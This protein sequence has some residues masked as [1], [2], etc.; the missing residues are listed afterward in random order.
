MQQRV[1]LGPLR[2]GERIVGVMATI[3]DVTA[4]HRRRASC[5]R[6][7]R[8][9]ACARDRAAKRLRARLSGAG[10][11][12]W[13]CARSRS[14]AWRAHRAA[15]RR[16]TR[17]ARHRDF[18]VLSSALQLLG[19]TDIDVT[20][21]ARRAAAA[22]PDADLRIQ[23]ALALGEQQHAGARST[24][25]VGALDDP[26][27]NVRFHAIEALGRLRAADAVDALADI[28]ES[29]DFFLAFPAI[30]ALARISDSRV[31]PRLVPLLR[32]RDVASRVAEAL[33][34]LGGADVVR[35]LVDVLNST[36]PRGAD[37]ARA[38]APARALRAAATAAAR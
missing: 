32:R 22:T 33:G 4:R 11:D 3:E 31:A 26:D 30:D 19:A 28:A 7:A 38:G 21:A 23:A 12:D 34:E 16:S 9:D 24:R 37:R 5:D 18:N 25:C 13:R 15:R 29:D 8:R 2:E 17:C 36:G 1:T 14:P 6:C 35:P 10:D 20:D 27:A